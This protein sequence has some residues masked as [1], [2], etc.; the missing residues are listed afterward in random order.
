[1]N[2]T[3]L[4]KQVPQLSL[5]GHSYYDPFKTSFN[6]SH[7]LDIKQNIP[8]E[9]TTAMK[10]EIDVN[11]CHELRN[12]QPYKL[13]G[14]PPREEKIKESIPRIAPQWLRYDKQVLNFD[15]FFIEPVYEKREENFRVRKLVM[16]FYLDDDTIYINEPRAE[17]S[18]IPQGIFLK[19]MKVPKAEG[20]GYYTYNDLNVG[21]D[22]DVFGKV[23]RIIDCDDFT[24]EFYSQKGITLNAS[25]KLPDNQ[26]LKYRTLTS[27]KIVPPDQA[28]HKEHIEVKLGG[29]H[30][31]R[32]LEQFL[33]N[34]RKVLSFDIM[35]DDTSYDGGQKFYKMD[36]FL[37]D[38]T[39]EVREIRLQ[40]TGK[41]PFP[42]MLN[43][44]KLAKDPILTHCPG[45]QIKKSEYYKP[46]D[47]I[48][49]KIINIYNRPCLLF[50]CDPF[51]KEWY[52]HILGINQVPVQLKKPP[53]NVTYQPVPPYNGYGTVEDSMGSIKWLM[54][55]PPKKNFPKMFKN[56][57]HIIRFAAQMVSNR[58]DDTVRKFIISYYCGDD[59]IQVFEIAERNSGRV[60]GKFL[61]RKLHRNPVSGEYYK[62]TDMKIGELVILGGHKF[63][64]LKMDEYSEKYLESNPEVFPEADIYKIFEK[65][66]I[67]GKTFKT[68]D[69]YALHLIKSLDKRADGY[70]YFS[71]FFDLL[72]SQN[73]ILSPQE[74]HAIIRKFDQ[75]NEGKISL[76]ALY[77]DLCGH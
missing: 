34:D 51:T 32:N 41:D 47:L 8:T 60:G 49:G 43:R 50:D 19:R 76:E 3:N 59:T 26:Y 56:D 24:K 61:E 28:E 67:E 40:N 37:S 70:L 44:I 23:I 64:L 27:A 68:L 31:N 15:C 12:G 66:R 11:L 52:K 77:K 62:E 72:K 57:L 53:L 75:S 7:I 42:K 22:L 17:N 14:I 35:W 4:P 38:N 39:A 65:F 30:P 55:K 33:K 6:K 45:M 21:I 25:E 73:I 20:E 9:T 18:G 13:T 16:Y 36:F 5:P 1:M 71:E 2:I 46:V 74:E 58:P 29:G 54:P 10:E 69:E 63:R 48:L